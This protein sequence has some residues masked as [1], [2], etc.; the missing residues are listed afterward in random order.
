MNYLGQLYHPNLVKLLG[1]CLEDEHRLLVYEFMAR[2]SL[3]NH[4]FRS[5]CFLL[6]LIFSFL[7]L[8]AM[9]LSNELMSMIRSKGR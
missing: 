8:L 9:R 4:L 2:G 5:K 6:L 1:Y 3:E 7:I